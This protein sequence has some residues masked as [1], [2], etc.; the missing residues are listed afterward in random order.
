[1]PLLIVAPRRAPSGGIIPTPVSLRNL[2]ATVV[3]LLGQTEASPFPGR[4]LA[5]FW[6]PSSPR[7]AE[8]DAFVLSE[9]VYEPL[10]TPLDSVR[11]RSLIAENTL[12]VRNKNGR[13]EL[14]DLAADPAESRNLE[15]RPHLQPVLS[16]FARPCGESISKPKRWN[17]K[18]DPWPESTHVRSRN[19]RLSRARETCRRLNVPGWAF[20]QTPCDQR[21]NRTAA[22]AM[23][24]ANHCSDRACS[25]ARPAD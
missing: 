21:V 20:L 25:P 19:E 1:M 22:V 6:A 13:E 14:F 12:Y 7:A 8:P 10:N 16:R 17:G 2:P 11:P 9:A 23:S 18:E 15:R 3:D 4:S 5:R 24:G